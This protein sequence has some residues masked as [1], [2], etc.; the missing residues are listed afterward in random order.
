MHLRQRSHVGIFTLPFFIS[1]AASGARII[2]AAAMQRARRSHFSCLHSLANPSTFFQFARRAS[3]RLRVKQEKLRQDLLPTYYFPA[4]AVIYLQSTR[5][6]K[7]LCV[8]PL[9]NCG[10]AENSP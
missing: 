8:R 4:R 3:E 9:T 5:G 7:L 1:L 6:D 10:A 2:K